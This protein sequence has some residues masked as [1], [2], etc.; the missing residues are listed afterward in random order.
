VNFRTPALNDLLRG[1]DSP[2]DNR[3]HRIL[4]I[5]FWIKL[6]FVV[7]AIL[8]AIAFIST[9]FTRHYDAG[10]ILEWSIAFVFSFYVFSFAVDLYPAARTRRPR[11]SEREKMSSPEHSEEREHR[12]RYSS[13]A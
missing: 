8:L 6:V 13:P 2:A 10:A 1:P 9:T 11:R 4:R 5:S 12:G 7:L 3:E